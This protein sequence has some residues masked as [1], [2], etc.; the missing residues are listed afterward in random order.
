MPCALSV[1]VVRG[2]GLE[3]T[4]YAPVPHESM[5]EMS[6]EVLAGAEETRDSKTPSAIVERPGGV[7]W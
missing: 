6:D 2:S 4:W 3:P 7:S 1:A 5:R